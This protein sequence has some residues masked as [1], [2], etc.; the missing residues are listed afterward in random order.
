MQCSGA[1]SWCYLLV[2]HRVVFLFSFVFP[3]LPSPNPSVFS[4]L[5]R[6]STL[7]TVFVGVSIDAIRFFS[8]EEANVSGTLAISSVVGH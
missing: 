6:A 1:V 2:I 4:K 3:D 8:I 7:R 5:L